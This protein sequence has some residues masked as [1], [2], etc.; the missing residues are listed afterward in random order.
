[1]AYSLNHNR[2]AIASLYHHTQHFFLDKVNPCFL[3]IQIAA[4]ETAKASV[5]EWLFITTCG[6]QGILETDVID[7]LPS[8]SS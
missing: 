7:K 2:I 5:A 1:M 3:L 4:S 8:I 6:M